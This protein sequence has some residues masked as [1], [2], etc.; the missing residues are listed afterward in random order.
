M[1]NMN[2]K[3]ITEIP[4]TCRARLTDLCEKSDPIL[5]WVRESDGFKGPV[6]GFCYKFLDGST[7]FRADTLHGEWNITHWCE[8]TPP[9][10]QSEVGITPAKNVTPLPTIP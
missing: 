9:E 5:L 7:K 3:P 4:T 6:L 8:V 2:W 10:S 1:N